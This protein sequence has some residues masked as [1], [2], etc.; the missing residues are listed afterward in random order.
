MTFKNYV[1]VTCAQD[2]TRKY[3]ADR[4][5]RL[6]HQERG[7]IVRTLEYIIGRV[8]GEY[9]LADPI[10]FRRK[11]HSTDGNFPFTNVAHNRSD[12][13]NSENVQ[14]KEF[15]S[16]ENPYNEPVEASP[17]E[18]F[19]DQSSS[20]LKEIKVLCRS[21]FPQFGDI[22]LRKIEVD[23]IEHKGK[24]SLLDSY[25]SQFRLIEAA[26]VQPRAKRLEKPVSEKPPLS[27]HPHLR[28]L[29]QVVRNKLA[30]IEQVISPNN[31]PDPVWEEIERLAKVYRFTDD[32]NILNAA[33]DSYKKRV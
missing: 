26:L 27:L 30:E 23:L 16:N 12:S 9:G 3:S 14:R 19:E 20:K 25:L 7:K 6:L 2:F 21:I 24:E 18:Q 11:R 1:C 10:G 29:P 8:T 5:N 28:N 31:H 32:L 15:V 33:L 4:H 17:A 13:E 22:L